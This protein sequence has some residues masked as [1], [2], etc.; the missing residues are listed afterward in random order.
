MGQAVHGML[1][2]CC[3]CC[4]GRGRTNVKAHENR[5]RG[6]RASALMHNNMVKITQRADDAA[7]MDVEGQRLAGVLTKVRLAFDAD[8]KEYN[9][10]RKL[11]VEGMSVSNLDERVDALIA[12]RQKNI[13]DDH[14]YHKERKKL[15]ASMLE[16]AEQTRKDKKKKKK[17]KKHRHHK[18]YT[19]KEGDY[20]DDLGVEARLVFQSKS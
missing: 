17:K 14:K 13:D 4:G 11:L 7:D 19:G 2:C 18:N 8:S 6:R 15:L 9:G 10:I 1:K 20:M 16:G 3:F 5:T 12:A